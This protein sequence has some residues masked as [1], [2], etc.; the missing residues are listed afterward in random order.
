MPAERQLSGQV[1]ERL[2]ERHWKC[3]VRL[4]RTV[5]SNPTLSALMR[6]SPWPAGPE[7]G[8][9]PV[10]RG[11]LR[12]PGGSLFRR[13]SR[14]DGENRRVSLC[15]FPEVRLRAEGNGP[16]GC[17]QPVMQAAIMAEARKSDTFREM[18]RP[19][20]EQH[21]PELLP[22]LEQPVIDQAVVDDRS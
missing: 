3:R 8:A 2:K 1:S 9:S 18:A 16:A 19:I 21:R 10:S 17:D 6:R 7:A 11:D 5:G 15:P 20:V 4:V 14:D 22:V 12:V 13:L